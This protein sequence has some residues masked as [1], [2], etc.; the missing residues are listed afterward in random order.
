MTDWDDDDRSTRKP[1]YMAKRIVQDDPEEYVSVTSIMR[2]M[3]KEER[4]NPASHPASHINPPNYGNTEDDDR[5]VDEVVEDVVQDVTSNP[6]K[7]EVEEEKNEEIIDTMY[8]KFAY[9]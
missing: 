8:K 7:K 2:E 4:N 5:D 3:F 6:E 9:L 1:T